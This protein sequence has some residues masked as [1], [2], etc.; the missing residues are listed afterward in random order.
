MIELDYEREQKNKYAAHVKKC[1][2]DIKNCDDING[3][4]VTSKLSNLW[5]FLEGCGYS[6]KIITT[7]KYYAD[8]LCEQSDKAHLIEFLLD[9]ADNIVV[10]DLPKRKAE[11]SPITI[12]NSN[13]QI[14]NVKIVEEAIS[15]ELSSSQI[16]E[17]K[18]LLKKNKRGDIKEWLSN[19]GN[20]TLS[21]ILST[22]ITNLPG[23]SNIL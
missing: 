5:C 22:V 8:C 7:L 13:S 15:N 18:A 16:E 14:I 11:L 1:V 6:D 23:L 9:F 12:T 2:E 20:N 17:L 4:F 10:M 19:L 3:I 21:G